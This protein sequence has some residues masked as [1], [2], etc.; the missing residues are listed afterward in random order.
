MKRIVLCFAV[1][2][3]IVCYSWCQIENRAFA[4][5]FDDRIYR[6]DKNWGE[7]Q[8][9][10]VSISSGSAVHTWCVNKD[11]DVFELVPSQGW[12]KR[13]IY[14]TGFGEIKAFDIGV[15]IGGEIWVAGE[16][17]VNPLM[18]N[19]YTYENGAWKSCQGLITRVDVTIDGHA[20]AIDQEGVIWENI[21]GQ[22]WVLR[23]RESAIDIG[24]GSSVF[25]TT[26]NGELKKYVNGTWQIVQEFE[27]LGL[28]HRVDVSP[29]NTVMVVDEK[30]DLYSNW[31]SEI[32]GNAFYKENIDNVQDITVNS[33]ALGSCHTLGDVNCDNVVNILD[34]LLI[35][36]YYTG[37]ITEFPCP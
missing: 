4:L 9:L 7:V 23:G 2:I 27:G 15:G 16:V 6:L 37:I 8:G 13:N 28:A 18:R 12:V 32:G 10:A 31:F 17:I 1:T 3:L 11:G 29:D 22:G 34:A 30:G 35:A 5:K 25:I 14:I 24:C 33:N 26:E 19:V 20:W 36:Q 21:E